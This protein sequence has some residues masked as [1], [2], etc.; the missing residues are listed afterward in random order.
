MAWGDTV[1]TYFTKGPENITFHIG[2][3]ISDPA[4]IVKN[5]T[6]YGET[7]CI[8]PSMS[9]PTDVGRSLENKHNYRGGRFVG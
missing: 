2:D 7:A 3:Y 6:T 4:H 9:D 5:S 1:E 8:F